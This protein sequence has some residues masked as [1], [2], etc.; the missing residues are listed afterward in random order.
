MLSARD[1]FALGRRHMWVAVAAFGAINLVVLSI[2]LFSSRLYESSAWVLI[3]GGRALQPEAARDAALL[4][5]QDQVIKTQARIIQSESVLRRAITTFGISRLYPEL[6]GEHPNPGRVEATAAGL[7][8]RDLYVYPESNTDLLRVA[9]RHGDPSIAAAFT[10]ELVRVY[11]ERH[12]ALYGNPDAA[13]FFKDEQKRYEIDLD[14]ATTALKRFEAETATYAVDEQRKLYLSRRDQV[15]AGLA[16]TQGL[17]KQAEGQIQSIKYQLSV[18]KSRIT[19]P[20]EIFGST[21]NF[22]KEAPTKPNDALWT[23]PPLLHVKLYQDTAQKLVTANVELSGL[24]ALEERQRRELDDTDAQLKALSAREAEFVRLKQ[25][26]SDAS[27]YLNLYRKKAAEAKTDYAWRMNE[28]LSSVQV[29]QPAVETAHPVWP[30][31]FLLIPF[32]CV[33]GLLA[34]VA[35]TA[36]AEM[37]TRQGGRADNARR[38]YMEPEW[39]DGLAPSS[40]RAMGRPQLE[41]RHARR[42]QAGPLSGRYPEAAE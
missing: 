7:A 35:A 15:S 39:D 36:V 5:K 21:T 37:W 11:L 1:L 25:N 30:K 40:A 34:A 18:L 12:A 20:P 26:V 13:S 38:P 23:D 17:I 41:R 2:L 33:V 9:F 6:E 10:N 29:M 19:L 8:G 16:S 14:T 24:K 22:G 27:T 31:P 28:G 42:V 3:D 4:S 32:G